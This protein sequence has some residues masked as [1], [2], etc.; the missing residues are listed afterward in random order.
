M[1]NFFLSP[2]FLLIV[3]ITLVIIS[4]SQVESQCCHASFGRRRCADGKRGTPCCGKE[5]CNI[6]CCNCGSCR[7]GKSKRDVEDNIVSQTG[8]REHL[9]DLNKDGFYDLLEARQLLR[10]GACGNYSEK[11]GKF[12]SEFDRMDKDKDGKLSYEEING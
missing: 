8:D 6:F 11:V 2:A 10:S 5:S 9:H 7:S 1:A 3:S 12:P 4:E